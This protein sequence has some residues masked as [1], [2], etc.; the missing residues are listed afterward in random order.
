MSSLRARGFSLVELM[1]AIAVA[2]ILTAIAWPNFRDFMHRNTVTAQANQLLASLQYARNEAVSRRYPTA[3]CAS[4]SS[5]DTSPACDGGNS[6]DGGWMVWRDSSLTGVPAYTSSSGS[7]TDELLRVT[8]PQNG[9]SIEA[10]LG[11]TAANQFSFDQRGMVTGAGGKIANIVV[12]AKDKT[13]DSVGVNTARVPGKYVRVD[14]SG[15]IT[16]QNLAS[17]EKCNTSPG[18]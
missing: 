9:V 1:I 14:P 11:T 18:S 7:G 16:V 17:G 12:C 13:E 10:F 8:S 3:V 15:R 5:D 4:A 2:A 6:F